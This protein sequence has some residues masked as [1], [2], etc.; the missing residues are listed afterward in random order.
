[1]SLNP[2]LTTLTF[3]AYGRSVEA[4]RRSNW[5]FVVGNTLKSSGTRRGMG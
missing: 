3:R 5:N 1:V 4:A 2:E